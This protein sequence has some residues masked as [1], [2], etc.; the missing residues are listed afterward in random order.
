M[1]SDDSG[2]LWFF[3]QDNWE[4]MIKVLDGCGL[5]DR[6][7]VFAAGTTDVAYTLEVEDMV[8][9]AQKQYSNQLGV[10][11]PAIADTMAFGG[12]P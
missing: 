12:C 2:V 4:L 8:S 5:N 6:Y 11:S 10:R 9:G 1:S 7:W 3:N